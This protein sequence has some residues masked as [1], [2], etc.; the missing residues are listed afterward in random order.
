MAIGQKPW[1]ILLKGEVELPGKK[2]SFS[3]MKAVDPS[4]ETSGERT[5]KVALPTTCIFKE[6][7]HAAIRQPMR[8]RL[9]ACRRGYSKFKG[10]ESHTS[11][12]FPAGVHESALNP[13]SL[14]VF[15]YPLWCFLAPHKPMHFGMLTL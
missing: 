2:V 4:R 10:G 7:I 1:K 3:S 9:M 8:E 6:W 11:Y 14:A 12:L 15:C 13:A 5:A